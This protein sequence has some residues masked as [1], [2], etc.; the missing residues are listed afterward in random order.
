MLSAV[1]G[2]LIALPYTANVIYAVGMVMFTLSDT[3]LIISGPTKFSLRITNLS[4][5]YLGQLLIA[6]S[7]YFS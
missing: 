5:Y 4:L 3:V 6:F 7:L 1:V 2:K